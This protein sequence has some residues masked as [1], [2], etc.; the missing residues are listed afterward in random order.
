MEIVPLLKVEWI[1]VFSSYAMETV[2]WIY[3]FWQ[4][5]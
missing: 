2:F 5:L 4:N 1:L 3:G